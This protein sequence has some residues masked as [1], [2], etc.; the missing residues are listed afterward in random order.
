MTMMT[1]RKPPGPPDSVAAVEG[2]APGTLPA[3]RPMARATRITLFEREV[4]ERLSR[5]ALDVV[6]ARAE[7]LS[8]GQRSQRGGREA[9]FGSTMLTIE[10]ATFADVF[11]DACDAGTAHRLSTL[12]ESDA[13]VPRRIRELALREAAR[14]AGAR[15]KDIRTQVAVRAQGTKVFVDVDVEAAFAG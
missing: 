11:R 12:L 3:R 6:F 8:E 13:T 14:I 2:T 4:R 15:L 10:L 9:Y 7:S 5:A 1:M